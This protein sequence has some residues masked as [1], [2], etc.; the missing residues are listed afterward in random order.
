MLSYN[1]RKQFMKTG[2]PRNRFLIVLISGL[3]DCI[4]GGILLLYWLDLLPV[5]LAEFDISPGLAGSLGA[6][7]AVSGVVVV[8]WVLTRL[9]GPDG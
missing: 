5:D 9:K 6:L 4:F 3:F 1:T 7:M 2:S 8:T